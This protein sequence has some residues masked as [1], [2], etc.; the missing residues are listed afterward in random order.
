MLKDKKIKI[1]VVDD[2]LYF[3]KVLTK[4]ISTICNEKLY[5][6]VKFEIK[7]YTNAHDFIEELDDE[8]N[9]LILDYYLINLNE[10][11]ILT[12]AD[13]LD[14][15]NKH[16]TNCEVIMI[17]SQK[18]Q[19]IKEDL[20]SKGIFEY[21]DKNISSNNRIGAVIQKILHDKVAA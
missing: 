15:V 4:Y 10:S 5:S 11:D 9:I 12:G 17:S 13:V 3:N 20:K 6:N 14:E 16:C 21:I 18:S 8:T 19:T 1:V 7:T 2:D